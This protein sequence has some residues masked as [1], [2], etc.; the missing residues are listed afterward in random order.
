MTDSPS[1][2]AFKPWDLLLS[3]WTAL[4]AV[5]AVIGGFVY[6]FWSPHLN[7]RLA[8]EPAIEASGNQ[9]YIEIE[10]GGSEW[11]RDLEEDGAPP[12][13]GDDDLKHLE[14]HNEIRYLS[15]MH[16]QL[17]DQGLQH[18]GGLSNL[19]YLNLAGTQVSD[20]GLKYLVR[21]TNLQ[22]LTLSKNA[23]H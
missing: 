2:P 3:R 20:E 18:L 13:F 10:P 17:S 14:G 16:T 12:E 19:Q 22:T 9:V 23:S 7:Q 15:L 21:L 4:L 1:T 11:I 5:L 6:L 8:S